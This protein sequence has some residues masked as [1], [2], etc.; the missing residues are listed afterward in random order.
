MDNK[1]QVF[2]NEEFGEVRTMLI[3]NEPWFVA[4]DACS[5][6]EIANNRNAVARIEPD[7]KGVHIVDT[8][9]GKQ[10]MVI[11]NEYGLYSLILKSR[12]PQAKAFKR[13]I[14]HEVIPS[15]RK[16]GMYMTDNLLDAVV[17]NPTVL[18]KVVEKLNADR[19]KV[20]RL[21]TALQ[22]TLPKAVYFDNFV[23]PNYAICFRDVAK[24]IGIPQKCFIEL[25]LGY[26]FIYRTTKGELRPTS[27]P[28]QRGYFILRDYTNIHNGHRGTYTLVTAKGKKFIREFFVKKG[29]IENLEVEHYE[30]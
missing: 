3:D 14:T 27:I 22:K 21:E 28:A 6:L 11:I 7:E 9:G 29:I 12:K 1:L 24:E 25:L 26:K 2:K 4:S 19:C 23:D 30:I 20:Q 17:D 8:L 15:I 13:W 5:V 18:T 16:H 10:E